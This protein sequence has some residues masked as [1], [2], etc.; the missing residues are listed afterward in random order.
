MAMVLTPIRTEAEY[1]TAMAEVATLWGAATHT[2]SGDRLDLLA[3]QIDAY[4]AKHHA[5]S[6]P[7]PVKAI[8]FRREQQGLTR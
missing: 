2:P 5:I 1:E 3:T 4:E 6:A 7:D 8:A